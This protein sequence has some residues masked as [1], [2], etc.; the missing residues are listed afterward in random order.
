M[1]NLSLILNAVLLVAVGILYF[2]HFSGSNETSSSGG[3]ITEGGNL[4]VAYINSDSV[5]EHYDYLKEE[6]TRLEE[7]GSKMQS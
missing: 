1:K 2:L 3:F 7:K 4:S 6:R 5:L